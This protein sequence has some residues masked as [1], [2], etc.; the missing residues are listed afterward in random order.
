ML[1]LVRGEL[2][3]DPEVWAILQSIRNARKFGNLGALEQFL[4]IFISMPSAM[5]QNGPTAALSQRLSRLHW[6]VSP[7]GLV[8]DN[9]GN[10]STFATPLPKVQ[11]RIQLTWPTVLA[12]E[13]AHRPTFRALE[14]ADL[15]ELHR[16]LAIFGPAD[17]VHLR[18]FLDGTLFPQQARAHFQTAS[19]L[20]IHY[21]KQDSFEHRMWWCMSFDDC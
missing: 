20:C 11:L 19:D 12:F 3:N 8:E 16:A 14:Q 6:Y 18:C 10:F 15:F 4:G 21:G 13:V 2:V 7:T 9:L 5:P 17:Q 1:H